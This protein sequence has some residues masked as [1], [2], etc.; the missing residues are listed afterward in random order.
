MIHLWSIKIQKSIKCYSVNSLPVS[1]LHHLAPPLPR[2]VSSVDSSLCPSR[3]K[4]CPWSLIELLCSLGF[5]LAS[6]SSRRQSWDQS[7]LPTGQICAYSSILVLKSLSGPGPSPGRAAFRVCSLWYLQPLYRSH[8][9][10]IRRETSYRS[11]PVREGQPKKSL[12]QDL[13]KWDLGE[14]PLEYSK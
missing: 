8:P 1:L 4:V 6:G 9:Q 11:L 7:L 12:G 5:N 14:V 13:P 10:S 2:P 3:G